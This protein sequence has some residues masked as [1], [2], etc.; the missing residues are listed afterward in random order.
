[1]APKWRGPWAAVIAEIRQDIGSVRDEAVSMAEN[2][3]WAI[4]WSAFRRENRR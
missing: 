2:T 3:D 4:P 1:M